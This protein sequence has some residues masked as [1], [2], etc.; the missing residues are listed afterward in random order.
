MNSIALSE[1]RDEETCYGYCDDYQPHAVKRMF[2]HKNGILYDMRWDEAGNLGQVSMAKLGE[3]FERG[4]FLFWTEDNRMHTA[5][6]ENYYS[7]YVYDYSG[8]RRIKLTGKTGEGDVNADKIFFG[9]ILSEATLYPSAYLVF[10]NKGYTKHYFVGSDRVAARMG[11][12]GLFVLGEWDEDY[13]SSIKLFKQ[14]LEHIKNRGLKENDIK[15]INNRIFN[16]LYPDEPFAVL[17]KDIP[18]QLEAKADVDLGEFEIVVKKE[19]E[20]HD[21]DTN[22]YFYHTD[23][24]GSASWITGY[25]GSAVQHIQYL[26]YGEPYVNE[27]PFGYSER[28]LFTGKERDEETG[29]GYFGARYMDH[30]LM[31]MWLSVDPMSD[32]YPSI[33]PY[34]YCAWN[35][36]KLVD[37]DGR[38]FDP[39]ME[40]YASQV[41]HYC[42]IQIKYLS[43]KESLTDEQKSNLSELQSAKE[44]I[45]KMRDD[46]TTLYRLAFG[47]FAGRDADQTAGETTYSCKEPNATHRDVILVALNI[48]NSPLKEDGSLSNEGLYTLAHELK[49]CYQFYNGETIYAKRK[50][51]RSEVSNTP[52]LEKAAFRRGEAFRS[53]LKWEIEKNKPMYQSLVNISHEEFIRN[54]AGCEIIRHKK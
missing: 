31:T 27:R 41:E 38:D 18:C 32:K 9:S 46:K 44:E 25:R 14:S 28:F 3:M 13:S 6:D 35:P 34:A 22:V 15:C 45:Q 37:P 53:P 48:T 17:I 21:R 26:P 29:Y 43:G 11:G 42:D 39:T 19:Q 52:E 12:G 5:V 33:S 16:R 51:E 1:E 30:E 8:E 10:S 54:H 36:V 7:Y 4:R 24:L 23:H 20:V 49:H 2:D 40:K 47:K 50:G